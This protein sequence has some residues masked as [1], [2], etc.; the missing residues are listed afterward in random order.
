MEGPR[1]GASGLPL[2]P[3]GVTTAICSAVK[4]V[5]HWIDGSHQSWDE[6]PPRGGPDTDGRIATEHAANIAQSWGDTPSPIG[7]RG[8]SNDRSGAA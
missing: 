6:L 7:L 8:L 1:D 5:L 4:P 3:T 2:P